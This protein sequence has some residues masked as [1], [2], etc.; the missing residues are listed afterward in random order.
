MSSRDKRG[1]ANQRVETNLISG[2][3]GLLTGSP[4]CTIDVGSFRS[5]RVFVEFVWGAAT[6]VDMAVQAILNGVSGQEFID[7]T[8]TYSEAVTASKNFYWDVPVN[9]SQV[10]LTFTG[11]GV[12]T[13][14]AVTV[15]ASAI[16]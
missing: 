7:L 4:D 13:T 9:C 1:T 8:A 3:G 6:S 2:T 12:P 11:G 10:K 15:H 5:L 16:D 14:D